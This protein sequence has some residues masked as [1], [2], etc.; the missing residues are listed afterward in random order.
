MF[1][2]NCL[3]EAKGWKPQCPNCRAALANNIED[4]LKE[5]LTIA[6]P[7]LDFRNILK[8]R[9]SSARD[10]VRYDE[11]LLEKELCNRKR[12]W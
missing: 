4:G 2:E 9:I 10:A 12:T 8:I 6:D 7:V 5:P 1:H 3:N 11:I